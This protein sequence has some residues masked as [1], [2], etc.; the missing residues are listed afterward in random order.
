MI[1][2]VRNVSAARFYNANTWLRFEPL[3]NFLCELLRG[4]LME[5][6]LLWRELDHQGNLDALFH[7]NT[8][9][10][11]TPLTSRKPTA[12]SAGRKV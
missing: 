8:P 6:G 1:Y 3:L 2:P 7:R 4:D 9:N 5:V 12:K 10:S 11:H